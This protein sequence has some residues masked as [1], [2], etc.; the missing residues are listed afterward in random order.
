MGGSA[1]PKLATPRME[2]DLYFATKLRIS[3]IL[4]QHFAHVGT[5]VEAPGKEDY[6]DVD[7]VVCEPLL[8]PEAPTDEQPSKKHAPKF[9]TEVIAAMVGAKH[10][11][12]NG[13]FD[14]WSFAIPW[15]VAESQLSESTAPTSSAGGRQRYIQ[16]DV[17]ILSKIEDFNWMQFDHAHG[18]LNMIITLSV[19][20]K[21][22]RLSEKGFFVLIPEIAQDSPKL[23]EVLITKDPVLV[24][25]FLGLDAARFWQ[26][27]PSWDD[28]MDYAAQCRFHDPG[29]G[30]KKSENGSGLSSPA[31]EGEKE[32]P[33]DVVNGED[34]R[35]AVPVNSNTA[36]DTLACLTTKIPDTTDAASITSST[37]TSAPDAVKLDLELKTTDR[38]RK[39]LRPMY[40]YWIDE[41]L[42]AHVDQPAGSAARLTQQETLEEVKEFFGPEFTDRYEKQRTTNMKIALEP[43]LWKAMRDF[44]NEQTDDAGTVTTAFKGWKRELT[45]DVDEKD[46]DLLAEGVVEAR[47][48]F[49]DMKHLECLEWGKKQWQAILKRQ[50]VL[51][52]AKSD[53]GLRAKFEKKA[54]ASGDDT[55]PAAAVSVVAATGANANRVATPKLPPLLMLLLPLLLVLVLPPLLSKYGY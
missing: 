9:K 31:G 27:F 54:A 23:A 25:Q 45:G 22:L 50:S 24:L 47:T 2:P 37:A 51:D 1:F 15:P 36:Q 35:V 21:S 49:T 55:A 6:G 17:N 8:E 48:A 19:R 20:R 46:V 39:V 14:S 16:V 29:F 12:R 18:D 26:P 28:V 11:K 32:K 30:R 42:P 7:F 10:S 5:P 52:K 41:Y 34:T 33:T 4:K 38:K 43:K 13:S 44:L 40:R 3:N 53:A